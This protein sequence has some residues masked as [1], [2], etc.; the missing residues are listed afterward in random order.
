MLSEYTSG[1]ALIGNTWGI[2]ENGFYQW[3]GR[4]VIPETQ[5]FAW[6]TSSG[7]GTATMD[8]YLG[9]YTLQAP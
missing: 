2:D 7:L 9:G 3:Q 6:Q 8:V 1:A 4:I 5:A